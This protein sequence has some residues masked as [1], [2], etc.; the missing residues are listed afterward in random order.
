MDAQRAQDSTQLTRFDLDFPGGSPR[1]LVAAIQKATGKH[2]NVIISDEDNA[3]TG[4]PPLKMNNV[5][6][7][8]LFRAL[9]S[10]SEK[11]VTVPQP[12]FGGGGGGGG[13]SQYGTSMPWAEQRSKGLIYLDRPLASGSWE[14]SV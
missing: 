11:T 6:V 13:Y 10:S 14:G 2:L 9:E 5:D 7:A 4:L 12:R 1:E 3:Q 8:Q